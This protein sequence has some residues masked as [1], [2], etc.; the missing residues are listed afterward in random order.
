MITH[1]RPSTMEI[2]N[3]RRVERVLKMITYLSDW[4]TSDE[5][6]THL[7]ISEK[8]VGRYFTV[9]VNLGFE[10][11]HHRTRDYSAF[12]IQNAS[13]YFDLDA[14]QQVNPRINP[15]RV[16]VLKRVNPTLSDTIK[17]E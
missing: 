12:K 10:L 2:P 4:R 6:K 9:L 11:L 15:E 14:P 5:C 17:N 16:R 13:S 7:G 1:F 3:T 8:S